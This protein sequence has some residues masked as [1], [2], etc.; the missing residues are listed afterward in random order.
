MV[1]RCYNE[2]CNEYKY[3]GARG[4]TVCPAW[5]GERLLGETAS[6]DGFRKFIQDMGEKPTNDHSIDRIEVQ[7]NYEPTN[8]RW[9]TV[10][11]QVYNRTNTLPPETQQ[12]T[13]EAARTQKKAKYS[14]T[15]KGET[16]T[17]SQWAKVLKVTYSRIKADIDMGVAPELA[18]VS[19]KIRNTLWKK[20]QALATP[21]D[22]KKCYDQAEK[23]L[24]ANQT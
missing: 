19:A 24:K 20:Y 22:Y 6:I 12:R 17:I 11:E 3:Y 8:C 9:A 7:K 23:W 16:K 13:L 5:L 4:I 15:I 21:E 14:A 18:V 2:K 1:T 10:E